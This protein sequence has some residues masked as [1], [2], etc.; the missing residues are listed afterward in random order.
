MPLETQH[1]NWE[2]HIRKKSVLRRVLLGNGTEGFV[3]SSVYRGFLS[4]FG[5]VSHDID[6]TPKVIPESVSFAGQ[7]A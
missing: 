5:A 3:G 4:L 1:E 2:R 7:K 6:K